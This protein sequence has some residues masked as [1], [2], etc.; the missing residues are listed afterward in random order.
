MHCPP[1]RGLPVFMTDTLDP[2][3]M[4]LFLNPLAK[5]IAVHIVEETG[6]TSTDLLKQADTL[7]SPALLLARRQTAGRGRSGKT[8]HADS[9]ASLTFSLAWPFLRPAEDLSGLPLATGV[10]L[11]TALNELGVPVALKWPN[12]ILK[13]GKKLAGI[14]VERVSRQHRPDKAKNWVIIG[15]GINLHL[16]DT[17]AEKIGQPASEAPLLSRMDKNRLMASFVNRLADAFALFEEAGFSAF[18]PLWN[19]M[20]AYHGKKVRLFQEGRLKQS[21]T[22]AGIDQYGRLLLEENGETAAFS[23]GELSLRPEP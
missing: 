22:V 18:V 14:L 3:R 16:P 8:W 1:K 21:G 6:S 12:D 5:T 9:G 20:H 7:T 15:I 23:A 17:L 10:A 11:A 19:K 2:G 13:D 4:A